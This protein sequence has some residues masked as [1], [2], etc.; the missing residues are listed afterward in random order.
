M[1][2]DDVRHMLEHSEDLEQRR[3]WICPVEGV[4]IESDSAGGQVDCD[5]CG[6]PH[7][8]DELELEVCFSPLREI[9]QLGDSAPSFRTPVGGGPSVNHN[10]L[11]DQQS[12]SQFRI[13][14]WQTLSHGDYLLELRDLG[15]TAQSRVLEAVQRFG[16]CHL[17]FEASVPT[18][19]RL[20]TI[21]QW[22]GPFRQFQNDYAGEV[23]QIFPKADIAPTTG[24][25]AQALT[26][27]TDGTQDLSLPPAILIF[28]YVQGA[29][30]GGV[31]TFY[32][33]AG[34]LKELPG[35]DLG[36]LLRALAL[37]LGHC[38]KTKGSWSQRFDG[39]LVRSTQ[40][41]LA[42][43]IRIRLDELMWVDSRIA[44]EF[45]E[46]RNLI[47]QW[48][49]AH[50]LRFTPMQGDVVIFD[51]W[52][53]LHGRDRIEGWHGRAHDRIWVDRLHDEHQGRY[54]LGIRPLGVQLMADIAAAN[55]AVTSPRSSTEGP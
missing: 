30:F 2:V 11:Q 18:K 48:A 19:E 15:S 39:S 33:M 21:K 43:S 9:S 20:E 1:S 45:S 17:R 25:S 13:T 6:G 16:I 28:Q 44:A 53:V 49:E 29:Q 42:A 31:S 35:D 34:L 41:D 27:H 54:L 55:A 24:D 23:K 5:L 32:D 12:C 14:P 26:P 10:P 36:R 46:L 51:N 52:R 37:P 8:E 40:H 22:L 50:V 47:E 7:P 3:A 38:E 4:P